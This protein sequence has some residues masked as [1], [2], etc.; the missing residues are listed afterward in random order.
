MIFSE[1]E[2]TELQD[3]LG[4]IKVSPKDA[5]GIMTLSIYGNFNN[6]FGTWCQ[7]NTADNE[8][9]VKNYDKLII[10]YFTKTSCKNYIEC[11]P[12]QIKNKIIASSL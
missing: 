3:I 7:W 11:L 9:I 5:F 1:S 8:D 6:H 2:V 4:K 12:D 10:K